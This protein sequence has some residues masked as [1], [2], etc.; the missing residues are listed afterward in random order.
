MLFVSGLHSQGCAGSSGVAL[1]IA[2]LSL[3][4]VCLEWV[5][6]IFAF[7]SLSCDMNKSAWSFTLLSRFWCGICLFP[8]V[9]LNT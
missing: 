2:V 7:Y 5:R 8:F 3:V 4:F 6:S 1:L 9:F